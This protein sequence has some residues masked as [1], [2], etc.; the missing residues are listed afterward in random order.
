MPHVEKNFTTDK[1]LAMEFQ[2]GVTVDKLTLVDQAIKDKVI[3]NI[4]DLFFRELF[5]FNLVQT[6]PNYANFLFNDKT[7]KIILLDFGATI[8]VSPEILSKFKILFLETIK[9]NKKES[10]EALFDLG[11]VDKKLP[12]LLV[13]KLVDLYW[14]E[15]KSIREDRKI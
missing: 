3:Y 11:I 9:G 4:F 6:D 13:M 8:S 12:K 10:K 15:M 7:G 1:T 14:E 2:A 5:L